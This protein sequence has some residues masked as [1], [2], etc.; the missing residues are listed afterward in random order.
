MLNLSRSKSGDT[1]VV[2]WMMGEFSSLLKER[3][4]LKEDTHL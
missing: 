2:T 4:D 3:Y 1:C